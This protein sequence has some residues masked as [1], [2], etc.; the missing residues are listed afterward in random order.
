MS[1]G[2]ERSGSDALG[3]K[4]QTETSDA[5]ECQRLGRN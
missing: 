1:L 2:T 4:G 5:W 3:V